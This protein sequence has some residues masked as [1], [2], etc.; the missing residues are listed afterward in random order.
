[1]GTDAIS[2]KKDHPFSKPVKNSQPMPSGII[3]GAEGIGRTLRKTKGPEAGLGETPGRNIDDTAPE[4]QKDIDS[5]PLRVSHDIAGIAQGGFKLDQ[6]GTV[7]IPARGR[8]DVDSIS[9]RRSDI[10]GS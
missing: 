8:K 1:M 5:S 2:G 9:E 6:G 10:E 4:T 3:D 7:F